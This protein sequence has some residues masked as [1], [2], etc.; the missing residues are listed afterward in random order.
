MNLDQK[1]QKR[2]PLHRCKLIPNMSKSALISL[3]GLFFFYIMLFWESQT[4]LFSL[5]LFIVYFWESEVNII[6][7]NSI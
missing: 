6:V 5:F 2:F 3:K 1:N 7:L 4:S